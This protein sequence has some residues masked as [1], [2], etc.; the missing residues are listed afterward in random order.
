MDITD[1]DEGGFATHSRRLQMQQLQQQN[2]IN[3]LQPQQLMYLQQQQQQQMAYQRQSPHNHLS[4]GMHPGMAQQQQHHQ[5]GYNGIPDGMYPSQKIDYAAQVEGAGNNQFQ[6]QQK[7]NS[8]EMAHMGNKGLMRTTDGGY[9]QKKEESRAEGGKQVPESA[10][11][12][13]YDKS[14]NQSSNVDS[15]RGSAAYSSGRKPLDTSPES[16]DALIKDKD[17]TTEW[18]SAVQF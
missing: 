5:S 4:Q 16:S 14:G 1:S 8:L 12:S 11:S 18:V 2:G 9:V 17:N 6:P 3:D 10:A 13:D 7:Y 15:G